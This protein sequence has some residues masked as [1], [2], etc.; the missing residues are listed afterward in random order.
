MNPHPPDAAAIHLLLT[1]LRQSVLSL[2][3]AIQ[4][5]DGVAELSYAPFVWH[6]GAYFVLLSD[7][8]AH[9]RHLRACPQAQ[10]LLIEDETH[11]RNVFARQRFSQEVSA[12]RIDRADPLWATVT[13]LL[14][15]RA[16]ATVAV[17]TQLA[18]FHLYRLTPHA[19]RLIVGFGQA[20]AIEG[21]VVADA[22]P[23][24]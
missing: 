3:L 21:D 1:Q 11:A 4:T 2:I 9:S 16:G 7:L 13:A 24:R 17:L 20:Y 22:T 12:E 23:L 15:A 14:Q 18:D 19:G 5:A 6:A 10:I 8:A